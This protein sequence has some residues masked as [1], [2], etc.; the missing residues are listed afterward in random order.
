MERQFQFTSSTN[1]FFLIGKIVNS[2]TT[3][4]MCCD[5]SRVDSKKETEERFNKKH[6]SLLENP[7]DYNHFMFMFFTKKIVPISESKYIMEFFVMEAIERAHLKVN[8]VDAIAE[9]Q[10]KRYSKFV[11]KHLYKFV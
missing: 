8:D 4:C 3:F 2:G 1:G 9:K 7:D 6:L 5:F 11:K 10:L